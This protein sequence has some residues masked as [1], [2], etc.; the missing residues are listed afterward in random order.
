MKFLSRFNLLL[1]VCLVSVV[2]VVAA[3]FIVPGKGEREKAV[4]SLSGMDPEMKRAFT[5]DGDFAALPEPGPNDWL[6]SHPEKGQTFRK[7]VSSQPNLPRGK[8]RKLYLQPMGEFD[9]TKAP[10]IEVLREYTAAYYYPMPVIVLPPADPSR[11]RS[12]DNG[13]KKQLLTQDILNSLEKS[14]PAD[15]YST[16]GLTMT[17]LY[18]GEGWNFVFGQ[19]RFKKRVGVFSFARYHP[20]FFGDEEVDEKSVRL[21]VL[22]RAAKVLTHETSHMFGLR[23]C[24]YYHCNTNSANHLE[25]ADASPMHLCPVCLRKLQYAI[26]FDPVARYEKL[27]QFYDKHGF[28]EEAAWTK[29]RIKKIR[30]E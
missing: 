16:L 9:N 26:G 3:R 14:L 13:G 8:R 12:R 18:P 21:L 27:K 30:G 29:K 6:N 5:D 20:S 2:G 23:H 22:K 25:E 11:I 24:I 7:F 4:G 28:K 17:D 1:L 19:A 10:S 15:A